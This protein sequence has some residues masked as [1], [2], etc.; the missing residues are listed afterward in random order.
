MH[1]ATLTSRDVRRLKAR[2]A[3]LASRLGNFESLSQGSVMP[4][5]PSSWI[6]T[7]KLK[8]KTVTRTLSDP[9]AQKM[10]QAIANYREFEAIVH[11][12]R[13]ITQHL[14]LHAP[15]PTDST[16]PRKRPKSPLS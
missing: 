15:D 7:R 13:E 8:G 6:W 16:L 1:K 9:R 3:R 10:K 5:S 12:L 2:Y 4:K 11:E 14:I